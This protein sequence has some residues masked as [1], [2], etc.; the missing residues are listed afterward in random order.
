M[1]LKQKKPIGRANIRVVSCNAGAWRDV[2][3]KMNQNRF[4][5]SFEYQ[6]R[7][8]LRRSCFRITRKN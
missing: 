2:S 3:E 4:L 6:P 7:W 1:N 5:S 8:N